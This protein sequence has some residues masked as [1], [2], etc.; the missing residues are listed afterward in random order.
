M[1]DNEQKQGWLVTF[2]DLVMIM[3]CF[4]VLIYSLNLKQN[5]VKS[6]DI[7]VQK[8]VNPVIGD[9]NSGAL[10]IIYNNLKENLQNNNSD[11]KLI[12]TTNRIGILPKLALQD[13]G[14]LMSLAH[15][16]GSSLFNFTRNLIKVRL[17]LNLQKLKEESLGYKDSL[18][19]KIEVLIEHLN[20]FNRNLSRYSGNDSIIASVEYSEDDIVQKDSWSIIVDI[21]PESKYTH[22]ETN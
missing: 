8:N 7:D 11:I 12:Y 14:K 17:L 21:Y 2:L 6:Q 1:E 10:D 22:N 20:K 16:L 19:N 5:Q 15:K 18:D 4:F 9:I 3:T 13:Q